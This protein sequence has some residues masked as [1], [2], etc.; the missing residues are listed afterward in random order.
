MRPSSFADRLVA[1]GEVDDRQPPRRERRPVPSA[2]GPALS[3]PR[4][5]S[6]SFIAASDGGS[7]PSAVQDDEAADAAHG[8]AA[9]R[10]ARRG[11]LRIRQAVAAQTRR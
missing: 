11:L 7:A 3:G 9:P 1:A 10:S 5:T 8:S 2:N 4:W 6:V